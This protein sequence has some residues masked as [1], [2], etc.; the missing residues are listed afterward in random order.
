[1]RWPTRDAIDRAPH[2]RRGL[3]RPPD[4][5][6]AISGQRQTG[7]RSRQPTGQ[8]QR[9]SAAADAAPSSSAPPM[10]SAADDAEARR[11]QVRADAQQRLAAAVLLDQRA[12]VEPR[13]AAD[14]HADVAIVRPAIVDLDGAHGA[15]APQPVGQLR[16]HAIGRG[17]GFAPEAILGDV[18][19]DQQQRA[20][21]LGERRPR[22]AAGLRLVR[23]QRDARAATARRGCGRGRGRA[24]G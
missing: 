17:P 5:M 20:P 13:P 11:A 6:N 10:P 23:R 3:R 16:Q 2:D 21:R 12:D 1:M 22:A 18:A 19:G 24:A 9:D 14:E 8:R 7:R 4:A 15:R